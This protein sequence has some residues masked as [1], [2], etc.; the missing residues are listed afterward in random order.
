MTDA[1][2]GDAPA[3]DTARWE[4]LT[5]P[6]RFTVWTVRLWLAAFTGDP[7]AAPQIRVAFESVDAVPAIPL[8]DRLM[9]V[10]ADGARRPVRFT[11]VAIPALS[12]DEGLL[13]RAVELAQAEGAVDGALVLRGMLTAD[14]CRAFRP[15]CRGFARALAGAGL[16]LPGAAVSAPRPAPAADA[17][18]RARRGGGLP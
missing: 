11:P 16:R 12:D 3:F 14:A 8:L 13:L 7:D 18:P 1:R 15:A 10:V 5:F 9:R 6:E 17:P 2:I 4:A